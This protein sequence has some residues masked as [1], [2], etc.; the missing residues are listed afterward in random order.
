MAAAAASG[1]KELAEV[2]REIIEAWGDD[3]VIPDHVAGEVVDRW[4]AENSKQRELSLFN[5]RRS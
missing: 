2:D 3:L 1:E 5:L 4:L